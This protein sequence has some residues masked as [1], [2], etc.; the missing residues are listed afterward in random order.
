MKI[1]S[2]FIILVL[3]SGI[4]NVLHAQERSKAIAIGLSV[5]VPVVGCYMTY[6][7]APELFLFSFAVAPSLGHFYAEQWGRGVM[8]IAIRS[9]IMIGTFSMAYH[10]HDIDDVFG[11][12]TLGFCG[13]C[14]VTLIDWMLV[15]SSVRI[16]NQRFQVQ[17]EINLHDGTYGI[18]ISYNF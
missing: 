17:P 16:Y 1:T 8:F 9:L 10:S 13:C 4:P 2:L 7:G 5:G 18:G 11:A 12:L 6:H 3:L 14:T 15:P